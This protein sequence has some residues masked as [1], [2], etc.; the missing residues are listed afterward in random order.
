MSSD[1]SWLVTGIHGCIG[2]WV[3]LILAKEDK[4]V[5]GL[6][7]SDRDHR[8]RLICTP[9]QLARIGV[10]NG[11]VADLDL[12]ER[13]LD[14]HAIT[15]V[16]HLAALQLPFCRADPVGGAHVNV[17]GTAAVFEAA[18]RH[19]LSTSLSYASSAAVYD[20][21]GLIDGASLYGVY[22][23]ATEGIARI[24]W[25]DNKVASLGLRPFVVYGPGRDQGMTAGPTQ[26]IAAAVAGGP[27]NIAFGGRTQLQY[28]ADVARAFIA[29]ARTPADGATV[30]N[31]GGP[32]IAMSE[33]VSTIGQL[34]PGAKITFDDVPLPFPPQLP[35]PVFPMGVTPFATGVSE[36]VEI[37]RRNLGG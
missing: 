15:H 19:G 35:A 2:A 11:D 5:V 14:E 20:A 24:F 6:D 21:D 18:R 27:Y 10:V 16:V 12:L 32:A 9:E 30:F 4:R 1:E 36:S 31:L 25:Q 17:V 28:T 34:V 29:A 8:L 26:A 22:K 13:T 33:V 7:R 3:G 37:F 23:I